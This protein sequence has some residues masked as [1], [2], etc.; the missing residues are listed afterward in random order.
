MPSRLEYVLLFIGL[1][2]GTYHTDQLRVMKG[3]FLFD[4]EGPVPALY[5]FSSYDYGPFDTDVYSDLQRL[6]GSGLVAEELVPGTNRR[7]FSLTSQGRAAM[8]KISAETPA[9]A[10]TSLKNIKLLVT[11]LSF[12]ALL[13]AV[14]RKYPAYASRSLFR[15]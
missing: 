12:R 3:M 5:S 4:Q 2:A 11:S 7:V 1:P 6:E 14:Y 9:A 15:R 8:L 13:E 10:L